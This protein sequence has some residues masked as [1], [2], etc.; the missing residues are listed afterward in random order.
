MAISKEH[1]LNS[2]ST[3]D[4]IVEEVSAI[5]LKKVEPKDLSNLQQIGRETFYETFSQGNTAEDMAK[6]LS[7]SFS[8]EKLLGE[9]NNPC[10]NFY[11][12][13]DNNQ[14][15]GYLK[16]NFGDAQTENQLENA[17]EIERIYVLKTYQGKDVG[18]L[19]FNKAL[20]LANEQHA[21]F[22][23]L[24]VWEENHRAIRFYQKNG[25]VEFG[26]HIFKLGADEQ[27]DLLLKKIL[28]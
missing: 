11:L 8:T 28:L 4:K 22:V 12:A 10:S 2:N 26:K 5:F 1:N 19:L 16:I 24:G 25:F 23:W 15:I 20:Q 7:E 9:I 6:Y 14:V 3:A 18:Q 27:T 21:D 17:F 13:L